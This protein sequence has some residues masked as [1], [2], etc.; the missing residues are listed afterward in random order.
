MNK[1]T[2]KIL[3][4]D[5][6]EQDRKALTVALERAGYR[7]IVCAESGER[8]TELARSRTPD[9]AILDVRLKDSNGFDICKRLRGL[10]NKDMKI[11]II[12]GHLDASN[13]RK[14]RE[15]GANDM[16]EKTFDF[17]NTIK[18]IENLYIKEKG[19]V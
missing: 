13:A 8:G 6:E 17:E 9:V 15:S 18:S 10:G 19:E 1:A 14:A 16:A 12:T 5:D 3:L 11:V 7:D 2:C 4:I